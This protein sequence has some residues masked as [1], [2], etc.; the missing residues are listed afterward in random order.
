MPNIAANTAELV[1]FAL[2]VSV[3]TDANIPIYEQVLNSID[4]VLRPRIRQ[5]VV[6]G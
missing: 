2:A 1:P 6:A 5:P 3:E 4:V